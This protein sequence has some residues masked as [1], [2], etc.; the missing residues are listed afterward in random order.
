MLLDLKFN[1]KIPELSPFLFQMLHGTRILKTLHLQNTCFGDQCKFTS[2]MGRIW[3]LN[4][5]FT[6]ISWIFP[7]KSTLPFFSLWKIVFFHGPCGASLLPYYHSQA[8]PSVDVFGHGRWL[9]A[10]QMAKDGNGGRVGLPRKWTK[11]SSPL[12]S[13]NHFVKTGHDFF[14]FQALIFRKNILVFRGFFS[15]NIAGWCKIVMS[16]C[17]KDSL[18]VE[19]WPVILFSPVKGV[20][21][22]EKKMVQWAHP[23]AVLFF[24]GGIL[25]KDGF[26]PGGTI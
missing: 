20:W 1:K 22:M 18:G 25:S 10:A 4:E 14:I 9:G 7:W 8:R 13:R 6:Y 26:N 19:Y 24:L 17:A 15:K 5:T 12:K 16:K 23:K 3:I 2:P 21:L 11:K